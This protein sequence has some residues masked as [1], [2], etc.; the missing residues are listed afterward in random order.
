[1]PFLTEEIWQHLP[2][3][4]ETIMLSSWPEAG[5]YKDQQAEKEMTVLMEGYPGS[6][7]YPG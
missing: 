2:T 5:G 7:Q 1:M 3:K 4:G 6:T